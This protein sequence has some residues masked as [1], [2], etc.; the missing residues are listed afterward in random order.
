MHSFTQT[1]YTPYV[2]L[3]WHVQ[4]EFRLFRQH[5]FELPKKMSDFTFVI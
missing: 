1:N 2:E 3:L 5:L 4:I